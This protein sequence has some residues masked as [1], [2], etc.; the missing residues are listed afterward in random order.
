MRSS[1]L[2]IFARV[3]GVVSITEPSLGGAQEMN[4]SL[5]KEGLSSV[6]C[7]ADMD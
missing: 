1:L 3:T 7:D 5:D 4:M 6:D 2:T